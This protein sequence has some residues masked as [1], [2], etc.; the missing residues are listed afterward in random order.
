MKGLK[1]NLY[2]IKIDLLTSIKWQFLSVW[3]NEASQSKHR[4]VIIVRI[5]KYCYSEKNSNPSPL[6]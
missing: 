2:Q 3:K 1:I 4:K 5:A 6:S